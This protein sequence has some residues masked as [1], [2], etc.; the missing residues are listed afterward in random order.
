MQITRKTPTPKINNTQLNVSKEI[1]ERTL[2]RTQ[3]GPGT[4]TNQRGQ[5]IRGPTNLHH[6]INR[7]PTATEYLIIGDINIVTQ[8]Y[9]SLLKQTEKTKSQSVSSNTID[10][11]QHHIMKWI[12]LWHKWRINSTK[13]TQNDTALSS[14]DSTCKKGRGKD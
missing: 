3:Q 14:K 10:T 2:T 9:K 6:I 13:H 8:M 11:D 1:I 5:N 7:R 4:T 12:S